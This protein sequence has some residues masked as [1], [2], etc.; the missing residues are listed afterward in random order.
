MPDTATAVSSGAPA[1][2]PAPSSGGTS[3][4]TP[5]APSQQAFARAFD[6]DGSPS[7]QQAPDGSATTPAAVQPADP[8]QTPQQDDR[9]PFIPRDRFDQVNTRKGQLEAEL[10]QLAWARQVSPQD[11]Q[12]IQQIARHFASGDQV[13]GLKAMIAEAR[14][15]PTVNAALQSEAA[16]ILQQA[17]R[18]QAPAV[19]LTPIR[20]QLDNGQVVELHTA[21]QIAAQRQQWLEQVKQELGPVAQTVDQLN[22]DRQAIAQQQQVDHFVA[23]TYQEVTTTYPGM[24]SKE[25]RAALANELAAAPINPHDPMQVRLALDAA[26]RKVIVP[27]LS[28]R[29]EGALLDKLKT[30]A[31]GSIGVNPGSAG[32]A[33]P[34]AVTRFQD[35]G[36]DAWS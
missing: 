30:Q 14:K 29:A 8:S 12:Q 24:E 22:A 21:Q 25:A 16:R 36:R 5:S 20:V 11:F 28:Q 15:D 33:S 35:L 7:S 18:Q 4:S 31:A 2:A 26:Y 17:G 34:R 13:A 1:S 23:N 9:S 32:A 19:D 27:T 10:N 3:S 6:S